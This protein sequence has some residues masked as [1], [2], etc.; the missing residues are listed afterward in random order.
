[1]IM[2]HAKALEDSIDGLFRHRA[3]VADGELVG[4]AGIGEHEIVLAQQRL[5]PGEVHLVIDPIWPG[6]AGGRVGAMPGAAGEIGQR[7][8]DHA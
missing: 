2:H 1:M 8:V 4:I 5:V 7:V 3:E 6:W